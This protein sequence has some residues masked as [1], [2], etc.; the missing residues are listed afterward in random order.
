PDDV[1][2]HARAATATMTRATRVPK[3][4]FMPKSCLI[5]SGQ[6]SRAIGGSCEPARASRKSREAL[7]SAGVV[8]CPSDQAAL[9]GFVPKLGANVVYRSGGQITSAF[10]LGDPNLRCC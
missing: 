8:R 2:H 3:V 4:R 5:R 10:N 9:S 7:A 1:S 6:S